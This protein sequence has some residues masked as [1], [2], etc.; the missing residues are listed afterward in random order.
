M[1]RVTLFLVE[2]LLMFLGINSEMPSALKIMLNV[3]G[4]SLFLG[5][6]AGD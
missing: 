1:E 5:S 6:F 4:L 2:I 3:L